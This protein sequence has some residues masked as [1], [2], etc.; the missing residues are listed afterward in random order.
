MRLRTSRQWDRARRRLSPEPAPSSPSH[1]QFMELLRLR[2]LVAVLR[3][4]LAQASNV[5]SKAAQPP[6]EADQARDKAE[7][8]FNRMWSARTNSVQ[9]L[10]EAVN[11]RFT[12]GT[13][14]SYVVSILGEH[15]ATH[16]PSASDIGGTCSL[17]YFCGEGMVQIG[18]TALPG[19]NPPPGKFT[20]AK[21]YAVHEK[22]M[23]SSVSGGSQP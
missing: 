23:P 1:K 11:R 5:A 17:I 8:D 22:G 19:A 4:Q 10:A 15:D 20:G 7:Q 13:P 12:N 6:L 21:Y 18:T 2:G 9:E 14:T 16:S 3:A